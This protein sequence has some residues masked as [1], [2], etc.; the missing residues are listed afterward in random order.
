MFVKIMGGEPVADTDM[1]KT[2]ILF[3]DVTVVS[4][5]RR[6]GVPYAEITT[7]D[8]AM[9]TFEMLGNAYV[10]ND[11]GMFISAFGFAEIPNASAAQ[12]AADEAQAELN[13]LVDRSRRTKH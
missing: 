6:D 10:F 11:S 4:F 9:E 7:Y 5:V 12:H 3:D 1:R 13:K 2:H 8:S